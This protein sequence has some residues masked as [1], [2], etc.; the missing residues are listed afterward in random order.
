MKLCKK[1]VSALAVFSLLVCMFC[2]FSAT[3]ASAN[4]VEGIDLLYV[5]EIVLTKGIDGYTL[6]NYE[7]GELY[8]KYSYD[9]YV[10]DMLVRI[11]YT[12]GSEK[13]AGIDDW[14]DG[15]RVF[16]ED[17]QDDY[18]WM[19]GNS[20]YL[21]V[22]YKEERVALQ[23]T[24]LSNP[25][26]GIELVSSPPLTV[27]ENVSGEWYEFQYDEET[28][29]FETAFYYLLPW[30]DSEFRIR[31][32]YSDGTFEEIC[33][34]EELN[35][36]YAYISHNQFES[37]WV[38]GGENLLYVEYGEFVLELPVTVLE[39][40]VDR[41]EVNTQPTKEYVNGDLEQGMLAA[42]GYIVDFTDFEGLTFTVYHKDGSSEQFTWSEGALYNGYPLE[43]VDAVMPEGE[44]GDAEITLS[45][46]GT[47]FTVT[48]PLQASGVQSVEVLELPRDLPYGVIFP[49]FAG[50]QLKVTYT[51][52]THKTVTLDENDLQ[53]RADRYVFCFD[54]DGVEGAITTYADTENLTDE[55]SEA[56]GYRVYVMDKYAEIAVE[57]E[58]TETIVETLEVETLSEEDDLVVLNVT[59]LD[60]TTEKVTIENAFTKYGDVLG[61]IGLYAGYVQAQKGF[62]LYFTMSYNE[63][64]GD[65]LYAVSFGGAIATYGDLPLPE[66]ENTLGDVNDD[67]DVDSTDARLV[68]QY[69]VGSADENDLDLRRA[70]VNGDQQV[71]STDARLILQYFVG[72]IEEFPVEDM[73]IYL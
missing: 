4:D 23:V 52:G 18:P 49:D 70:D 36:M 15:E 56:Y 12:N 17:S 72:T 46:M 19:V 34:D 28:G 32:N 41:V 10:S 69:F 31:V 13:L 8:T 63:L 3:A 14:V 20:N 1:C 29:E 43:L 48:T 16:I 11:R 7:T 26:A 21:F 24:I 27:M 9:R 51:D 53:Y 59:Y 62:T 65:D 68:L 66:E 37:P 35:G 33:V 2:S 55:Y 30:E 67:G 39:N 44:S 6:I 73:G 45:Y 54:V 38:P 64:L 40:P 22:C 5:D 47:E 50:L 71:N 58:P 61:E 42:V 57:S 25:M 60:G